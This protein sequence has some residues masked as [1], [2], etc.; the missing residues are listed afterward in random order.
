MA[1]GFRTTVRFSEELGERVK[2][3]AFYNR[4]SLNEACLRLIEK[5]LAAERAGIGAT[6]F[7]KEI[8]DAFMKAFDAFS[9]SIQEQLDFRLREGQDSIEEVRGLALAGIAATIDAKGTVYDADAALDTYR[10]LGRYLDSGETLTAAQDLADAGR[11]GGWR[12]RVS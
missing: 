12:V 10:A 5:G 8:E 1:D 3:Y 11:A 2:E 7:G 6:G 4:L 9:F